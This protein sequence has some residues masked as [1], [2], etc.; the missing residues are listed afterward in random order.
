[1]DEEQRLRDF[2][3]E[4]FPAF[5]EGCDADADLSS[6]VDSLGLFDLV[7]FVERDFEIQIPTAEFSP[8]KFSSISRMLEFIEE[9]RSE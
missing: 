7:A 8:Q 3:A 4:R 9:L 5:D 2:L 1:M 6:V